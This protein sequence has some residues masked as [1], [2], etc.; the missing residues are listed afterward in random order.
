MKT[1]TAFV[2]VVSLAIFINGLGDE[3]QATPVEGQD[4]QDKQ[5]EGKYGCENKTGMFPQDVF[6]CDH[7][8]SGAIILHIIGIIY[9]FYA[10]ALVCDE[11]FVPSLD[12]IT[13]KVHRYHTFCYYNS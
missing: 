3:G 8:R 12:V 10:L 7:L 5:T 1:L 13:E 2:L 6:L 11:F 4:N 9:M